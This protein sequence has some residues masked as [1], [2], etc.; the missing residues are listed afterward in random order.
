MD[1][2]SGEGW[3]FRKEPPRE[4]EMGSR[5][6]EFFDGGGCRCRGGQRVGVQVEFDVQP[7]H[8]N[9]LHEGAG[10]H[11]GPSIRKR[12]ASRSVGGSDS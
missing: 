11:G 10:E 9:V 12:P 4:D 7:S 6:G 5:L 8:L 2:C 1:Y 3:E